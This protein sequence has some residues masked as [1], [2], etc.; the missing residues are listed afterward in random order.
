MSWIPKEELQTVCDTF[1]GKCGLYVSLPFAGEIFAFQAEEPMKAASTIKIPLL[2]LL[3]KDA[4]EGRVDLSKTLPIDPVNRVRGSGVLKFL[5]PDICISLY[6]YAVLM[7]IHSDNA[8]TNQVIDTVGIRRANAYFAENGWNATQLNK[9]LFIPSAENPLGTASANFTSAADLGR[10]LEAMLAGKLVSESASSRMM[11]IMACQQ[12]GKFDQSLPDVLRPG[13]TTDP[14]GEVP[15][16]RVM[17][18]QKGGTL[19]DQVSHDA[20]IML[21]PNGRHAV[22]VMMTECTDGSASL[23]AIKRVSRLVYDRLMRQ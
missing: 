12:L 2:A 22:M 7:M 15:P 1:A 23:E 19:R 8:A 10:M 18:V 6:D 4:E 9:K 11:S 20:A 21:L 17:L 5:S 13:N 3:F 14:L 16:G